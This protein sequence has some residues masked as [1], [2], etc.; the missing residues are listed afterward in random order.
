MFPT[1]S[2]LEFEFSMRKEAT[3]AE[4]DPPVNLLSGREKPRGLQRICLKK[5]ETDRGR[6]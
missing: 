3:P 5:S 4:E 2:G 6:R 1:D